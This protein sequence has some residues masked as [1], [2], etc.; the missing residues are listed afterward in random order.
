MSNQGC[1]HR[2]GAGRSGIGK[3]H[4]TDRRQPPIDSHCRYR[5]YSAG[6]SFVI[7]MAHEQRLAWVPT[8]ADYA[9]FMVLCFP[10]HTA[11]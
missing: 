10:Q 7:P 5:N 1:R 3:R 9:Q 11:R 4:E 6:N 2:D 8:W